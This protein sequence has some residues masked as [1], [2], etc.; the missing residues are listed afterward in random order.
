MPRPDGETGELGGGALAATDSAIPGASLAG[1]SSLVV[2]RAS[3][4]PAA[5][6]A[7]VEY[8]SQ[9]AQQ[10][11]LY[12]L[13]GDLPARRSSWRDSAM[14]HDPY[15]L[16]FRRQ[17]EHVQPVPPLPEWDQIATQV[18]DHLESV[19]R[20]AVGLDS[21]LA[22]LDRDVDRALEKRRWLLARERLNVA[23]AP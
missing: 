19:V 17:L 4:H 2:F 9:P 20:G 7:L 14:A 10:L 6:W 18:S 12:G 1:G 21:A 11:A 13:T 22:A 23:A 16:A 3:A 15:L 5:A 8:L